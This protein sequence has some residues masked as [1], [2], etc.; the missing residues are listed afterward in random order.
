MTN[1]EPR[2]T[3]HEWTVGDRL[4]AARESV[5]SDRKRFAEMIGISPDT[6]RAYERG[7]TPPKPP[8]LIAWCMA[9]GFSRDWIV[10]GR[11]PAP[12][13]GEGVSATVTLSKPRD[14]WT[15]SSLK[16]AA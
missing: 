1:S 6:V 5:T 8:A 16:L 2:L 4:R 12:D 7:D 9:T 3:Y 15:I 13:G 10:C 11:V 14:N